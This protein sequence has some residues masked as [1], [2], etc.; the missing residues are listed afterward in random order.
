MR[1]SRAASLLNLRI[2]SPWVSAFTPLPWQPI[3]PFCADRLKVSMR[4]RVR[5]SGSGRRWSSTPKAGATAAQ[6]A[7]RRSTQSNRRPTVE[8]SDASQHPV[9]YLEPE[10]PADPD[11]G[12]MWAHNDVWEGGTKYLLASDVESALTAARIEGEKAGLERA[13]KWHD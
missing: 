13:A 12:R 7:C 3:L 11:Y 2:A 4:W 1:L 8:Q 10:P 6:S 5:S 9:I